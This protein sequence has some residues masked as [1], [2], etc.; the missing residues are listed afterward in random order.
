MSKGDSG[1]Q[2][3]SNRIRIV[4][5]AGSIVFGLSAALLLVAPGLFN[6]LLGLTTTAELEWAMRMIGITLVALTGNMFSVASRGSDGSVLFSAR[7]MLVSAF[8]LGLL[9]LLIPV[10]LTW[11]SVVYAIVGFGFSA[12]YAVV[13]FVKR[14]H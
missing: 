6:S 13:V 8:A 9:T 10:P 4:L 7:V 1:S 11:F 3:S 5:R 14:R 2:S 12:A